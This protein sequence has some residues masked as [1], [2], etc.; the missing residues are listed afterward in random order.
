V[1]DWV[2]SG[3]QYYV[4]LPDLAPETPEGRFPT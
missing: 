4:P 2:R 3:H 1:R